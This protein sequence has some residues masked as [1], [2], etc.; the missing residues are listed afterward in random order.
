[1]VTTINNAK[2]LFVEHLV[3]EKCLSTKPQ[4]NDR[5]QEDASWQY[6]L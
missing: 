3:Y 5:A 6:K 2:N 4:V 1:M